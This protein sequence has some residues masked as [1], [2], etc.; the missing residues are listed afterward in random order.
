MQLFTVLDNVLELWN[1]FTG[2]DSYDG[3]HNIL[4]WPAGRRLPTPDTN[5]AIPSKS[6]STCHVAVNLCN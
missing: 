4:W 1:K 3:P 2:F 5:D 6:N